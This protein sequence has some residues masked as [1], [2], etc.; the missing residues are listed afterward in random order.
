GPYF[1]FCPASRRLYPSVIERIREATSIDP[2]YR[3]EGMLYLAFAASEERTLRQRAAWQ[4]R[5]GLG[6]G[7]LSKREVEKMEPD[8]TREC[9]MAV[10][11]QEDH[12]LDPRLMTRGFAIAARRL[13]ASLQEY[14]PVLRLL[15]EGDRA[16]GVE[17]PGERIFA[18]WIILAGGSWSG[19]LAGLARPVPT[20]PVKGQVLLLQAAAPFFDHILHSARIYLAPRLD[21]RILVGATEEHEAGFDKSVESGAVNRLLTDAFELVPALRDA[22]LSDTWAGL[23]PGTPDRRPIIGDGGLDGLILATGHFRNGILLAPLTASL[24][25]QY[26]VSGRLPEELLQFSLGRFDSMKKRT[27]PI[28][29]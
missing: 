2:Q 27:A 11:F 3:T 8:I 20:Y 17:L 13:G 25:T 29:S 6:V 16:V 24:V 7:L 28:G 26:I 5:L 9:T 22:I 15:T 18:R 10:H 21:G 4:E 19:L 1:D 14:S 12:Q 23:R